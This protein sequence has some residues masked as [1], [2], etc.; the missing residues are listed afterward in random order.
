MV[1]LIRVERQ[2]RKKIKQIKK[3]RK[4]DSKFRIGFISIFRK[5]ELHF[6]KRNLMITMVKILLLTIRIVLTLKKNGNSSK[7]SMHI[8]LVKIF[9]KRTASICSLL[10]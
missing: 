7:I 10:F 3:I 1:K 4:L 5:R 2:E 9:L 8:K 6:S